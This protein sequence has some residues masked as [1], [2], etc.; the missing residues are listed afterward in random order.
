VK[1][2]KGNQLDG[3]GKFQ[4]QVVKVNPK[5]PQSD[6]SGILRES[7]A[8]LL[9]NYL[10]VGSDKATRWYA[11][12]AID[13]ECALVNCIPSFIASVPQ[14]QH[15][16][17]KAKLP[18]AGDDVMSQVG[19]T[20]THKTLAK[21]L[22]D[23]GALIEESYQLNVGGDTDFLNMLEEERLV[24]KRESK[25]SAVAAMIPYKV[26][27]KIG[28][29]DYIP[30]LNNKK[31]CY[32]WFKGKYFGDTPFNLDLKLDVVDSPDS[33]GIVID[34]IRATK[35]ARD[36][37]V[38]GALTSISAYAFKHPPIQTPYEVA[39]NWVEE[40]IQGKRER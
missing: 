29:S 3:L 16:F 34:A 23:R 20:V 32:I 24:S 30:F 6:V 39:R 33:A 28:P 21:M 18:V 12:Q 2:A 13:A 25:T 22:V 26:P 19:A 38:K 27:L 8:D 17:E 36:R 35:L 7:K 4:K 40:F 9:I 15:K 1:V 31:I 10:P 11:Q 37:G 5:D 14:W